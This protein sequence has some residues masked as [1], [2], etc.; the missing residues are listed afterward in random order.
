M[1]RAQ[2]K[3]KEMK[4]GVIQ[5]GK[6]TEES[7]CEKFITSALV[8]KE[9]SKIILDDGWHS[10]FIPRL[11]ET[12]FYCLIQEEMWSILKHFKNPKID[13]GLLKRFSIIEIKKH[14]PELF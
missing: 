8:E 3:A 4:C 6:T 12:V 1:E 11:L 10:K 7:I 2:V 13:F 14:K 5:G 9:Y